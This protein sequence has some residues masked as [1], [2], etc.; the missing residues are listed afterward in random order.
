MDPVKEMPIP[1]QVRERRVCETCV[2]WRIEVGSE[3]KGGDCRKREPV[4]GIVLIS[5]EGYSEKPREGTWPL[6]KKDDWCGAW[7]SKQ[8]PFVSEPVTPAPQ[9]KA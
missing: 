2:W 1:E 7:N 5:T 8:P 4:V 9:E 3:W 6:T